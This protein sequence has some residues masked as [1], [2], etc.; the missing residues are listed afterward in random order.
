M[1]LIIAALVSADLAAI[2]VPALLFDGIP[3]PAELLS[4]FSRIVLV[5]A[6]IR[7]CLLTLGSLAAAAWGMSLSRI[8]MMLGSSISDSQRF[9]QDP[10][11]LV[12]MRGQSGLAE[13]AKKLIELLHP[14]IWQARRS[15]T[16]RK[17]LNEVEDALVAAPKAQNIVPTLVVLPTL[18]LLGLQLPNKH[19]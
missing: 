3:V 18:R 14:I 2:I 10:S 17:V 7:S 19:P 12:M 13:P 15:R 5:A 4:M 8:A 1:F 16:D 11:P 9:E 6:A